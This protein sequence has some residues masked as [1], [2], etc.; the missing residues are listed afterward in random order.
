MFLVF[1]RVSG[2]GWLTLPVVGQQLIVLRA[3]S[4]APAPLIYGVGLALVTA[5]T[6]IP[7]LAGAARVLNRDQV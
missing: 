1:Y 7:A 6:T 5:A 2:S 3:L 4:G